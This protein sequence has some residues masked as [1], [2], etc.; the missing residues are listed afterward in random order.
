MMTILASLRWIAFSWS[1]FARWRLPTYSPRNKYG[2]ASPR[3]DFT[4]PLS[5]VDGM[6]R[7]HDLNEMTIL[8]LQISTIMTTTHIYH[9]LVHKSYMDNYLT[10]HEIT[11]MIPLGSVEQ[12]FALWLDQS[13]IFPSLIIMMMSWMVNMIAHTISSFNSIG[14]PSIDAGQV[15]SNK[16][17]YTSKLPSVQL[18]THVL[19]CTKI[20]HLYD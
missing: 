10:Y 15:W 19:P 17:V 7:A 18:H 4:W 12:L 14:R 6:L 3:T 1:R 11:C 9:R 16:K 2:K 20:T 5:P 8:N 13:C